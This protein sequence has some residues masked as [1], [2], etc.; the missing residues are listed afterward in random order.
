MTGMFDRDLPRTGAN[1]AP[2]SP[3]S[4]LSRTAEV[5]P[6]KLAVVHGELRRTWAEVDAR[7]RREAALGQLQPHFLIVCV[8]FFRKPQDNLSPEAFVLALEAALVH[9]TLRRELLRI[10]IAVRL[11][12]VFEL[13]A[14]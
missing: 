13:H 6:D 2:L 7:C 10:E 12:E 5:Y 3:L 9:I 11:L 1:F 14:A 4:F 8:V